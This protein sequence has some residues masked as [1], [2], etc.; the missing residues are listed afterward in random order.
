MLGRRRAF[1]VE[2][3]GSRG[4]SSAPR[5]AGPPA[6]EPTPAPGPHLR[7]APRRA[8]ARS[9]RLGRARL[10]ASLGKGRVTALALGDPLGWGVK[11]ATTSIPLPRVHFPL[12]PDPGSPP[13]AAAAPERPLGGGGPFPKALRPGAFPATSLPGRPGSASGSR[14]PGRETWAARHP[15]Q[16]QSCSLALR[17]LRWQE[18]LARR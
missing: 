13:L 3:L 12:I 2:P 18:D 4:E 17:A 1:A 15:L 16:P 14:G 8:P 11:P 9:A 6:L 7:R 5:P 10:A